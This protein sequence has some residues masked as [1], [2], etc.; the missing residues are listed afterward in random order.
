MTE[1]GT[2]SILIKA[3]QSAAQF[4]TDAQADADKIAKDAKGKI[5]TIQKDSQEQLAS[6][7][8]QLET[9]VSDEYEQ[10]RS[11]SETHITSYYSLIDKTVEEQ[12]DNAVLS[13]V[14][15]LIG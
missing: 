2:V 15:A 8:K 9:A 7:R 10:K 5:A 13:V 12:R 3:E 6:Y 14:K 4:I 1:S 11:E